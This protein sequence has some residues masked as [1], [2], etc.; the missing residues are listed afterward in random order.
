M[1]VDASLSKT[2]V[3][4]SHDS[5]LDILPSRVREVLLH[6]VFGKRMKQ[7]SCIEGIS[8]SSDRH[9]EKAPFLSIYA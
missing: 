7:K 4:R 9:Q 1:G 6:D 5:C 8:N 3:F 2:L